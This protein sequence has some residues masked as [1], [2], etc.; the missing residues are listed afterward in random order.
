MAP[1]IYYFI[2]FLF[3]TLGAK[4][5]YDLIIT[6]TIAFLYPFRP[7]IL[8]H[9]INLTKARVLVSS[10]SIRDRLPPTW[11]ATQKQKNENPAKLG[12][13]KNRYKKVRR[14]PSSLPYKQI[15]FSH[16]ILQ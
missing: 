15:S 5:F 3:T 6:L 7:L 1:F 8:F 4:L 12:K 13:K 2:I 16:S 9:R 14:C 10:D 11:G